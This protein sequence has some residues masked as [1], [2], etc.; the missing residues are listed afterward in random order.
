VIWDRLQK[1]CTQIGQGVIYA[2]LRQL[3]LHPT[4]SKA[5]GHEKSVNVRVS[6]IRSLI[7]RIKAA[8]EEDRDVW[9]DIALI[10]LLEGI[11]EEYDA[12]KESL[13][14]QMAVTM[15]D[16]QQIL[17]SEEVRIKADRQTGFKPDK[18]LVIR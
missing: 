15:E 18:I 2:G 5:E 17:A 12:K 9:D 8:V 4:T 14:N 13:L 1:V 3:L 16:A 6:E 11:P 10:T 7:Y